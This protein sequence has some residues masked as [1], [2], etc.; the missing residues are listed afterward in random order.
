MRIFIKVFLS[1]LIWLLTLESGLAIPMAMADTEFKIISLKHRSAK[2]IVPALEPFMRADEMLTGSDY[3]LFIRANP[4]TFATIEHMLITLDTARQNLRITISNND[5]A[6]VN[7]SDI[8][9]SD[10]Q[11]VGDID[12]NLPSSSNT[13]SNGQ[14]TRRQSSG[15]RVGKIYGLG[16]EA[17]QHNMQRVNSS[18]QFVNVLDGGQ[19]FIQVG[20][21]VPFTQHWVTITQRYI[22]RQKVTDFHEVTT[23][24]TVRPRIV[25]ENTTNTFNGQLIEIEITPRIANLNESG[26]IDFQELSTTVR[27]S[28]GEWLDLGGFMQGRDE[29]SR[30]IVNY[31]QNNG[32]QN[33]K[34]MIKVD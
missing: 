26:S 34:I 6:R 23:G 9:L 29:V 11:R 14:T 31:N 10:S 30:E 17:N 8:G 7:Q 4:D 27:V 5:S 33:T 2:D 28:R 13:P 19:S 16:V 24:F 15:I 1:S 12:I 25:G 20:Q 21:I 22:T 3:H 32:S 18:Q